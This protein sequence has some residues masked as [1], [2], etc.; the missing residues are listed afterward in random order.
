MP[1]ALG[2]GEEF[3][4]SHTWLHVLWSL[5]PLL[6]KVWWSMEHPLLQ[7]GRR[8]STTPGSPSGYLF[9]QVSLLDGPI[10]KQ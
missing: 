4:T 2:A 3:L 8:I 7:G 9:F 1:G 6:L 5:R 10:G